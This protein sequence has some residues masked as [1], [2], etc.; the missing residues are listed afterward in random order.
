MKVPIR[1]QTAVCLGVEIPA[2]FHD[3]GRFRKELRDAPQ[4]SGIIRDDRHL[5]QPPECPILV[6][7]LTAVIAH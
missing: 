2:A 1:R 4:L 6:A 5:A 3:A 7:G